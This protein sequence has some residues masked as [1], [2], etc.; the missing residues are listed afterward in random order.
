VE[1]VYN[2][3]SK[4]NSKSIVFITIPKIPMISPVVDK[5]VFL[6]FLWVI[7]NTT[8]RI[9][10][11]IP[12]KGRKKKKNPKRDTIKLAIPKLSLSFFFILIK[13]KNTLNNL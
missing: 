13:G 11:I 10:N 12:I 1:T 5:F 2:K 3:T 6:I 9:E 7:A 8:A 4:K